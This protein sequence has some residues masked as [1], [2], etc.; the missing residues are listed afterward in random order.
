[1]T[2]KC[3]NV[4]RS[5]L[6]VVCPQITAAFAVFWTTKQAR[7]QVDSSIHHRRPSQ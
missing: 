5:I 3:L 4:L 6:D 2:L 1:M 7:E